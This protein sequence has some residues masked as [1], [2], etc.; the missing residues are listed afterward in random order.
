LGHHAGVSLIEGGK[1]IFDFL[2]SAAHVSASSKAMMYSGYGY[3]HSGETYM[4]GIHLAAYFGHNMCQ[5]CS[6]RMLMS[7]LRI[8][9]RTPLLWA[10]RNGHEAAVKLLLDKNADVES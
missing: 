5:L 7:S 9:N 1:L 4:I 6:I 10:A 3:G 2:K 8:T